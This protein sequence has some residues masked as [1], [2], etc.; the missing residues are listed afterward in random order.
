MFYEGIAF[1]IRPKEKKVFA[2]KLDRE[3]LDFLFIA[4]Q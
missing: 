4:C 3:P 1:N 2:I